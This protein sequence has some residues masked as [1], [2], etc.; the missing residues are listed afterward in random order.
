M[1]DGPRTSSRFVTWLQSVAL[2]RPLALGG[3]LLGVSVA[4]AFLLT[5]GLSGQRIP[6]LG[7]EDI[8]R[9]FAAKSVAVFKASRDFEVA[10]EVQTTH[11]REEAR[12][13]VRPVFD[14]DSMV[15]S[16][17]KHGLRE[18]F[19]EMQEIAAG[20]PARLRARKSR[21]CWPRC[22]RAA[23]SSRPPPFPPTTKTSRCWPRPASL[24]S[25]SRR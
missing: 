10:D 13:R 24:P 25:S 21:S 6:E 3:V 22:T 17:V 7:E 5:P 2:P 18:A 9:P 8:G 19:T 11:R 4:A 20:H 12:A 15:E 16:K 23:G 1:A 14:Y